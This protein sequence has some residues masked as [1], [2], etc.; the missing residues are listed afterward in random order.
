MSKN[1]TKN[2]IFKDAET[3][4]LLFTESCTYLSLLLSH[5]QRPCRMM[6]LSLAL[7][8]TA[9]VAPPDL[10]ECKPKFI[11]GRKFQS[12]DKMLSLAAV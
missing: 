10:K 12:L 11:F 1:K 3:D 6:H 5:F 7:P 8:A 4:N 9:A 2:Y